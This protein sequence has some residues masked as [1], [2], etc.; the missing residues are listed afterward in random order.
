MQF[1]NIVVNDNSDNKHIDIRHFPIL[2]ST[3]KIY[4]VEICE[5]MWARYAIQDTGHTHKA[6]YT[7]NEYCELLCSRE[8]KFIKWDA[9]MIYSLF[10]DEIPM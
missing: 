1:S 10:N 3:L 2:Q 6:F 4:Q 9:D 5:M 8:L 7:S